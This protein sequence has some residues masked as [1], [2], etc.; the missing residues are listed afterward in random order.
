MYRF[1]NIGTRFY[2]ENK[3]TQEERIKEHNFIM[4]YLN[5]NTHEIKW[6]GVCLSTNKFK[7]VFFSV[8]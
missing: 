1:N 5:K 6:M 7:V 8:N 4:D 3:M 2:Y